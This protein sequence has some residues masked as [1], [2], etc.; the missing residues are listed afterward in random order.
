VDP[1]QAW[2]DGREALTRGAER[3]GGA[4]GRAQHVGQVGVGIAE[5]VEIFGG[6]GDLDGSL[7]H[8]HAHFDI[9]ERDVRHPERVQNLALGVRVARRDGCREGGLTVRDR[10]AEVSTQE[11]RARQPRHQQRPLPARLLLGQE[12]EGALGSGDAL[13]AAVERPLNPREP[14]QQTGI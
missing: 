13:A 2:R 11:L 5:V 1:G 7:H 6:L 14:G 12:G 9:A 4:P 8:L 3:L 10:V